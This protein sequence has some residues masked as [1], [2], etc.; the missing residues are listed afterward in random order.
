MIRRYTIHV[1][2]PLTIACLSIFIL[3]LIQRLSSLSVWDDAYFFV[4][5]ADNFLDY[6]Q[7][8]WNF[9]SIPTYGL[10]SPVYLLI[11][12]PLRLIF[13]TEPALVMISASLISG[14]FAVFLLSNLALNLLTDKAQRLVLLVI[15][16][17]SVV[18]AGEHITT[19]L[20]SGMD[21]MFSIA[22]LSLWLSLLL[23]SK[24]YLLT[25]MMA[26]LFLWIR[27]D[28]LLLTV[29]IGLLISASHSQIRRF[30]V[31]FVMILIVQIGVNVLYFGQP[32]PLSFYAKNLTIYGDTFYHHYEGISANYLF[33]FILSYPYLILLIIIAGW[34]SLHSKVLIIGCII[35]CCY[36]VFLVVPIMGFSQRFYYPIIPVL[37]ILVTDAIKQ[38]D[39][40]IPNSVSETIRNYPYP[41]FFVPLVLALVLINPMPIVI[42][43]VQYT[44]FQDVPTNSIGHFDLQ[45]AYD[46]HYIDSWY[47]LDNLSQLNDNIV[48]AT[49]EVGLPSVMNP[50]KSIIDLAGL[51]DPEY[52]NNTFVADTL[53]NQAPYPD[54]IYMPFPHY[55]TMW[56]SIYGYPN[57]QI[58]YQF[59]TAQSLGTSMDVAIR[60]ASPYYLDM[61]EILNHDE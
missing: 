58:D 53:L 42:N 37:L 34:R 40:W 51:N 36:Q 23:L 9:D 48:I 21:T 28:M 13:P 14:L 59:F 8:S 17:V 49:T 31:G 30:A 15:V 19:H 25:G 43:L 10:T 44:Q 6:G 24:R 26:S 11:V 16:A 41:V 47:G 18:V 55:E 45:T 60:R 38:I 52:V 61:L 29:S 7:L 39:N 50:N 1:V 27:P 57:F 46:N 2:I 20:T 12:I 33:Q 54:W 32:L 5:Y 35:F 3:M 56:Y 4:R 22:M